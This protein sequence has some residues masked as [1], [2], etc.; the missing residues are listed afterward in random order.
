MSIM[1][2]FY[3]KRL[4]GSVTNEWRLCASGLSSNDKCEMCCCTMRIVLSRMV[5]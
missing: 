4:R 3:F 5:G 2:R 1:R